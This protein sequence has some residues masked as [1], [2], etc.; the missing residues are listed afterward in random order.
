M[1]LHLTKTMLAAS[2]ALLHTS[3]P[4]S[5]WRL[6]LADEVQFTVTESK[7]RRGEYISDGT[8]HHIYISTKLVGSFHEL[9][10]TMAHEM[11]HL[12]Q[13]IAH[14]SDKAH[15]GSRFH[16]YADQVCKVHCF[17]RKAF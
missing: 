13:E 10:T 16:K 14:P 5:G 8:T 4:F 3:K 1:T 17:D 7:E 12:R 11:C 6:P 9:I 2:Y 15:H